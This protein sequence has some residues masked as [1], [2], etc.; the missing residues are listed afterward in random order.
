M[1]DKK[2]KQQNKERTWPQK[3]EE[4][5]FLFQKNVVVSDESK[6]VTFIMR[7]A[8]DNIVIASFFN[9]SRQKAKQ[10]LALFNKNLVPQRNP[11]L[12]VLKN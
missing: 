8:V 11:R 5:R 3:K 1:V 12:N 6:L 4:K 7:I 9:N 2:H 10:R